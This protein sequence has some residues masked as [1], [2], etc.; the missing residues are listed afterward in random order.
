MRGLFGLAAA[1]IIIVFVSGC[2]QTGE[3]TAAEAEVKEVEIPVGVL[4]DLSGPLT[5]YGW[6][7]K[8]A[9][10]I[11]GE[12]VNKKFAEDGKPYR[13]K[14]YIEDTG[15]DP[16]KALDT[17]MALQAKGVKLIV[18]PMSS[19][20]LKSVSEYSRSNKIILA[21]PSSTAETKYIGVTAPE[22]KKFIFRFVPT[23]SFQTKGIAELTHELGVKAVVI[24]YTGNAWG[25]GLEEFG[26]EEFE[27][28]G[29]EVKTSV[30]YPNPPPADF[31]PYI[32][33]LEENVNTL[34]KD[35]SRDEIAVVVFS[36]EE[37]AT[38]LAQT[39]DSSVL[40]DVKWVGCDGTAKSSKIIEDVPEKA[41]RI[42]LFST[43]SETKGGEDFDKLN[44]TYYQQIGN[45]PQGYGLNSYDATWVLALSFAEVYDKEGKYNAD[46]MAEA[47]PGM[48]EEYSM[49]NYGVYPVSG[50]VKF[51]EYRDRI[52]SRY[53]IYAVSDGN[54]NANGVWEFAT[55]RV[56]WS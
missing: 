25:K 11:A 6:D 37:V 49:G 10:T 34:L 16:K 44:T 4:V 5:T 54:W 48:A 55:N 29:V 18:G 47:M 45:S 46:A 32:A 35:Y 53:I 20:E 31:T 3:K 15:A 43:V 51:N 8:T 1:I 7:I 39:K 23:D 2:M 38:M 19:G 50:E 13:V 41:S 42:K 52:G 36:Y 12:D 21:S 27:K 26:R 30:E 56:E 33:T 14:L 40:L 9:T 22:E 28:Q 24:T 17:V